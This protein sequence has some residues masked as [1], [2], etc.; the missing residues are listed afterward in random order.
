[1]RPSILRFVL[2]AAVVAT[3]PAFAQAPT[4]ARP[5]PPSISVV[6]AEEREIVATAVVNGTLVPRETVAIAPEVEGLRLAELMADEGDTVEAGTVLARLSTEAIEIEIARNEAELARAEANIA[7]AQ[8]RILEAE[9]AE[10]EAKAAL[11]RSR[12]LAQSGVVGNDVLETRI[13]AAAAAEAR[14]SSARQGV[15]VG[16]AE[17]ALVIATGRE[18]E[19][20]RSRAEVRTPTAGLVLSRAARIG[21]TVSATGGP[22]FEIARDGLIE[23]EANVGETALN[24][25]QPGQK[26]LVTPAGGGASLEGE[27]RLVSPTVDRTTRLGRLRVALAPSP[28]LKNGMFARGVVEIARQT[29]TVVPRT[30]VVTTPAGSTVQVVRDGAI[31]TRN[32]T[33]GIADGRS[34]AIEDGLEAGEE[35]VATAGTFVRDGDFVTPVAFVGSEAAR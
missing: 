6:S 19:L 11:A 33:L 8:S 13:S 3:A 5:K 9:A 24:A 35:V 32:V 17:K 34:V 2:L 10:I 7:Q 16:Q 31:E 1:M 21:T 20:R 15:A 14:L 23:L 25:I 4:E 27:I 22:L 28:L 26:V 18:L 30:A 12:P 29:Q